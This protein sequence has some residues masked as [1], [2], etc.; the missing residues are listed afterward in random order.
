MI[1]ILFVNYSNDPGGAERSLLSLLAGMDRV[2]FRPLL[3]TFGSGPLAERAAVSGVTT[4]RLEEAAGLSGVRRDR[5]RPGPGL[6]MTLAERVLQI[7]RIM[8]DQTIDIVHTNN[9]KSHVLGVLAAA[10][11]K[12]RVVFHM[13]DIFPAGSRARRL[14]SIIGFLFRPGVIAISGAVLD[15]LPGS[16]KKR[17]RVIYNGFSPHG[18]PAPRETVRQ[19]LNV[20]PDAT[21]IL[22]AGRLVPWKGFALLIRAAVPLLRE[23]GAYLVI[24]GAP[25]YGQSGYREE[26]E[27][28]A[29]SLSVAGRVILPGHR[30]DIMD[31]MAAADLFVLPSE[32][33]P[34]GRSLVEAMLCG[35]PVVAFRQGGPAEI[36]EDGKTG[37][38]VDERTPEAL[39]GAMASLMSDVPGGR[40]MGGRARI[41]ASSRF[42]LERMVSEVARFHEEIAGRRPW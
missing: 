1:S 11:L 30:E 22:A 35:L 14:F 20:T 5:L 4:F 19:S 39:G 31:V 23:K 28:L 9:P 25:L 36:I 29:R 27:A 13:R 21:L 37:L 17:A 26:L 33:E 7:R 10:G 34:F 15:G 24:A 42:S 32:N 16:L 18:A 12:T 41:A 2:R 3:L 8:R 40:R 6:L 38:L